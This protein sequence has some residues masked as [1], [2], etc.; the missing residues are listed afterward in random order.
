M[1]SIAGDSSTNLSLIQC[2][3]EGGA[4]QDAWQIFVKKYGRLIFRWSLRWGAA[5]HDAEDVLQETLMAIHQKMDQYNVVAGSNFRSW[6]KTVA[7]HC[8][9]QV[10]KRRLMST[11]FDSSGPLGELVPIAS[12]EA[13]DDLIA[14]FQA[15]ADQEV[16]ELAS[17]RVR[18]KVEE[19]TWNCFQLNYFQGIP[20]GE[21]ASMLG[22]S[23]NHVHVTTSRL[24]RM[25]REEVA[26]VESD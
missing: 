2:L 24:R 13:R 25:L 14:H 11:S 18:A 9:L 1:L 19:K 17:E 21:V 23:A 16:L 20:G 26:R 12:I 5:S 10:R 7:Y 4:S 6:L 3:S 8:W 22:I 15:M